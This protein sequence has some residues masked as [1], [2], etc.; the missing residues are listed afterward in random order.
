MVIF[1]TGNKRGKVGREGEG[2]RTGRTCIA[3]A[4]YGESA[5]V[6]RDWVRAPM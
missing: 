2:V 4:A 5:G 3:A 6:G 1:I